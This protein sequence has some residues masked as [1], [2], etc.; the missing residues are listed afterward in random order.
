ADDELFQQKIEKAAFGPL[1]CRITPLGRLPFSACSG[2][3]KSLR[4]W[5]SAPPLRFARTCRIPLKKR[6]RQVASFF[7]FF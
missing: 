5:D 6:A 2:P 4:C 1:F 3:A 7:T